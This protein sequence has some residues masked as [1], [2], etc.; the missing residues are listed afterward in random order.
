MSLQELLVKPVYYSDDTNLLFDF[1]IPVLSN[2]IEYK[3]IAGYFSSNALAIAAKGIADFII[4]G[5]RIKLITNVVLSE[6]DNA[7]IQDALAK[8]EQNV[9]EEIENLEDDL[10]KDH[11]KMLGWLIK[12]RKLDI[13]VAVLDKGIEHQKIGILNDSSGNTLSFSGSDNETV[14]GWLYNDEQF[15]VFRSWIPGDMEHLNPDIDRFD[16]LWTDKGNKVRVY[17]VSDAFNCGLIKIAPEDDHEFRR[18]ASE[19]TDKLIKEYSNNY[20][21]KSRSSKQK[22]FCNKLWPFQNVAIQAW[23]DSSFNGILSMATGTGKTN[24]AIGGI[25]ELKKSIDSLFVVI[26]SPQNTI[27]KQWEKEISDLDLFDYSII[28]DST[29]S[30][31][32]SELADSLIDYSN[33]LIK[34]LV[35]FTTYNT[36]SNEKFIN[37]ILSKLE[38]SALLIC[39]E[40]HWAGA[41][42]FRNGLLSIY[43]YRL[44]LSATPHRYMD[45][46][47]TD[48]ILKY[49]GN[50][51]YEFSL[52]RALTEI[53]PATGETFL[54]P[55]NYYPIFVQLTDDERESYYELSKIIEKQFM[56]EIKADEVSEYLQRLLEKRQAIVVNANN[57][58]AVLNDLLT[59]LNKTKFML[60][61][62][63]PQQIDSVQDCLNQQ[64]IKNHRFT[65]E[66]GTIPKKEWEFLSE[67]D[68]IILNFENGS[69]DALVAMKCLDEGVN[70]LRAETGIFMASS[71]NPKQYIQRR[72]RLLRRHPQKTRVNIYDI[73]IV[74]YIDTEKAKYASKNDLRIIDKELSRYEEFANLAENKLEAMNEIFKIKEMYGYFSHKKGD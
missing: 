24:T 51:C 11:I 59:S 60:L 39:D 40:V 33:N 48:D 68:H 52:Q 22:L 1:Y 54:C 44:G 27:L 19:V 65:G 49:F 18:L 74:P 37:I 41:N 34:Y 64:R 3:R 61:Y 62:C 32:N 58:Y 21:I 2:S 15:H 66:E 63:S 17:N 13:K 14:H 35:V 56:R 9:I 8:R 69:Y 30:S 67:R 28:A 31:W 38:K 45:D 71:G 53:N 16:R 7:S 55:Y 5:G 20:R 50:V 70:V 36:L 43:Q 25:I 23:K 42:T 4:N 73:L 57:K 72:G 46:Y 10:K 12:N 47:G 26:C 6:E 29:N